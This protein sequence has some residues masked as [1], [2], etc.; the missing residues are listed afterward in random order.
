MERGELFFGAGLF[1]FGLGFELS[2]LFFRI[3]R[4]EE[5]LNIAIHVSDNVTHVV[6]DAVIGDAALREIIGS[7][8]LATIARTDLA[9]ALRGAL[10]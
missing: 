7:D 1:A 3:E 10:R 8:F 6:A 5:R 4:I 2:A 9:F